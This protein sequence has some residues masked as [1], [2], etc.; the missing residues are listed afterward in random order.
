MNHSFKTMAYIHSLK[1]KKTDSNYEA[2]VTII[3]HRDNNHVIAEYNGIRCSAIFNAFNFSY[4][5]DDVYG[6][7]KEQPATLGD[8]NTIKTDC[9]SCL[10]EFS[11]TVAQIDEG[12]R[13]TCPKCGYKRETKELFD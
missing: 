2:E 6:K 12:G 1:D 7:L 11:F 9:L 13:V 10:A 8:E 4:Y 5:V 3:E